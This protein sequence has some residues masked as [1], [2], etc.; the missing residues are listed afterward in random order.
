MCVYI[1]VS[2]FTCVPRQTAFRWRSVDN[3]GVDLFYV[4]LCMKLRSSGSCEELLYC[5]HHLSRQFGVLVCIR[6]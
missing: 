2:E 1:Y 3:S 4:G 5:W 6:N